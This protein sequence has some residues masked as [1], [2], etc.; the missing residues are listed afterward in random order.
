[1]FWGSWRLSKP[2]LVTTHDRKGGLVKKILRQI[3]G[4]DEYEEK[5]EEAC[6]EVNDSWSLRVLA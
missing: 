6:S 4:Y 5:K 2:K 1:M 3:W